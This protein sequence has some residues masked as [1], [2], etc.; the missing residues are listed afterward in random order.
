[1]PIRN[2]ELAEGCRDLVVF[3]SLEDLETNVRGVRPDRHDM[4]PLAA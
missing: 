3:V 1:V 4:H 2:D